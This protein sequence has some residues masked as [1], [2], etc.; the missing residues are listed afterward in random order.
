MITKEILIKKMNDRK[1]DVQKR[2]DE[3]QRKLK[4]TYEK[5]TK[6]HRQLKQAENELDSDKYT[7]LDTE[8]T[9]LKKTTEMLEKNISECDKQLAHPSLLVD[10]EELDE[11]HDYTEKENLK[12]LAEYEKHI[13]AAEKLQEKSR[14]LVASYHEVSR[15]FYEEYLNGTVFSLTDKD[16][17]KGYSL[18]GINLEPLKARVETARQRGL[19]K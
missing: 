3:A 18:I 9:S 16:S 13:L 12:L 15:I 10:K 2:K 14:E 8:I 1:N 11:L 5:I 17:Y 7:A 6:K 19:L 4:E